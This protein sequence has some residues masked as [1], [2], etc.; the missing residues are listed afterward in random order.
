MAK[1]NRCGKSGLFLKVSVAGICK[2]CE[3]LVKLQE[4]EQ[5]IQESI[6]KK[7]VDLFTIEKSYKE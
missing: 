2:E 3:R 7:Q 5:Q 1:C 4:G 6:A